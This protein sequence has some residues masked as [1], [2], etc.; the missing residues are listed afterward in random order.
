MRITTPFI[1]AAILLLT[2]GRTQETERKWRDISDRLVSKNDILR[3]NVID[4]VDAN[5]LKE[6][7]VSGDQYLTY[8]P[9]IKPSTLTEIQIN[10]VTDCSKLEDPVYDSNYFA[11]CDK[12]KILYL[13]TP[14]YPKMKFD[15]TLRIDVKQDYPE[16]KVTECHDLVSLPGSGISFIGCSTDDNKSM[17]YAYYLQTL[18]DGTYS[19]SKSSKQQLTTF[20]SSNLRL[21]TV[22]GEDIIQLVI[23]DTKE[24]F[25]GFSVTFKTLQ[26][27]D[28]RD[29]DT[30]SISKFPDFLAI[31]GV[32]SYELNVRGDGTSL[33][34]GAI[35]DKKTGY[36][37]QVGKCIWNETDNTLF[38]CTEFKKL[39]F[40]SA[41]SGFPRFEIKAK[42]DSNTE[43][44]LFVATSS[45]LR[46]SLMK[47]SGMSQPEEK[48]IKIPASEE[49]KD[50]YQFGRFNIYIITKDKSTGLKGLYQIWL[51]KQYFMKVNNQ[52]TGILA[53]S[54]GFIV[55]RENQ[56]DHERDD[57]IFVSGSKIISGDVGCPTLEFVVPN[58]QKSFTHDKYYDYNLRAIYDNGFISNSTSFT[59][60]VIGDEKKISKF[61]VV[62]RYSAYLD[63]TVEIPIFT[64]SLSGNSLSFKI[65]LPEVDEYE[66]ISAYHLQLNLNKTDSKGSTFS[67]GGTEKLAY[68]GGNIYVVANEEGYLIVEAHK[69]DEYSLDLQLRKKM[70][71]PYE[72]TKG[73][74]LI[75]NGI[76]TRHYIIL[77]LKKSKNNKKDL[78]S[79]ENLE[80][81]QLLLIPKD[82]SDVIFK[83]F[84]IY[85]L[86]GSVQVINGVMIVYAIAGDE[87]SISDAYTELI[88]IRADLH[89]PIDK[90]ISQLYFMPTDG[91]G[92]DVCGKELHFFPQESPNFVVI[93]NCLTKGRSNIGAYQLTFLNNN[94]S[95][96]DLV[97]Y[98]PLQGLKAPKI[99]LS[100][101][102]IHIIESGSK[103]IGLF[104]FDA[105]QEESSEFHYPIDKFYGPDQ[106]YS[107]EL[108]DWACNSERGMI[109]FLVK[110]VDRSRTSKNIIINV[111]G[112]AESDPSRRIH[113][114]LSK[115][116]NSDSELITSGY[117]STTDEV[118][119]LAS[120]KQKENLISYSLK[121]DGPRVLINLI[122]NKSDGLKMLRI[123][124][125]VDD[126]SEIPAD[127]KK[128][129][130]ALELKKFIGTAG[131]TPVENYVKVDISKDAS[132]KK[133]PI[134]SLIQI[135]GPWI[136]ID[137]ISKFNTN[138]KNYA[139]K[140]LKE[141]STIANLKGQ[142]S[143]IVTS[144]K[145]DYIVLWTSTGPTLYSTA[146]Y[147]SPLIS[148]EARNKGGCEF[149]LMKDSSP[150][151]VCVVSKLN[152]GPAILFFAYINNIW[153]Q[154]VVPYFDEGLKKIRVHNI[155]DNLLIVGMNNLMTPQI[156][157]VAFIYN[158][159]SG[160]T[161]DESKVYRRK[162]DT[163]VV[164]IHSANFNT[165]IIIVA[166]L[167][168]SE[169]VYFCAGGFFPVESRFEMIREKFYRIYDPRAEFDI[170]YDPKG[171]VMDCIGAKSADPGLY[172]LRCMLAN[173]EMYAHVF[174]IV[175]KSFD[176]AKSQEDIVKSITLENTVFMMKNHYPI[177]AQ[178]TEQYI[179]LSL[180]LQQDK[181]ERGVIGEG[182]LVGIYNPQKS[183]NPI[184]VL[185]K[186]EIELADGY[187]LN[188]V[189]Q[190]NQEGLLYVSSNKIVESGSVK[191]F[192]INENPEFV[193]GDFK[194]VS[195]K[196]DYLQII[197]LG[198]TGQIYKLSELFTSTYEPVSNDSKSSLSAWMFWTLVFFAVVAILVV[199]A[200]VIICF[201]KYRNR[202]DDVEVNIADIKQG[203]GESVSEY[204]KL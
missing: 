126:G 80:E 122:N 201:V 57:L 81:M 10:D 89:D 140:L 78:L 16:D 37:T 46:Y 203:L 64:K 102:N 155:E 130:V 129:S 43:T 68:I 34:I 58:D 60:T 131:I 113:S 26:F 23:L 109:H 111:N 53:T 188:Y 145:G 35:L 181:H 180:A 40:S 75:L 152:V 158:E 150:V 169:E 121:A 189:K 97:D 163:K 177:A 52:N 65:S 83:R 162:F 200:G 151:L 195:V 153:K 182:N 105:F 6:V 136:A 32:V 125:S 197:D 128:V 49:I 133:F 90:I 202:E 166:I 120:P 31:D 172:T 30:H 4:F 20:L 8:I 148:T 178:L 176:Q 141:E 196:N 5:Q 84:D 187:S 173:R 193:V 124:A 70:V 161:V 62:D 69:D 138:N 21:F 94:P 184:A 170:D 29:I 47:P 135:D 191:I 17:V 61:E 179:I 190:E 66:S 112:R 13:V 28:F 48:S 63:S 87:K 86:T 171:S 79:E 198:F 44:Y 154:F 42:S 22:I 204:S 88:Y 137:L 3:L 159:D 12:T 156:E 50:F 123:T 9:A 107:Q 72:K 106:G 36:E 11:I 92:K 91:I 82:G 117:Q 103:E 119:I 143:S 71:I 157:V 67:V 38:T 24:K 104:T 98:I 77:L 101:S 14:Q 165:E 167:E 100:E 15:S 149:G 110:V 96:I 183:K 146:D 73:K 1:L 19:L 164:N 18:Q 116:Q 192:S 25:K 168:N 160:F 95:K 142:Y 174:K 194:E 85:I 76:T 132:V 118:I 51:R 108:I 2:C 54:P 115:L 55:M 144:P 33:F 134:N 199:I 99:C 74:S 186:A 175:I 7:R 39:A 185:T 147:K 59:V 114:V 45:E 127:Q 27:S 41:S 56:F 139:T 93:S